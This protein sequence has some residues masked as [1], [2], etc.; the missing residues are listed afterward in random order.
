MDACDQE[1]LI[2][3]QMQNQKSLTL[4]WR[5]SS[6]WGREHVT[7]FLA[8]KGSQYLVYDYLQ[9]VAPQITQ[10]TLP[11][12]IDAPFTLIFKMAHG[13]FHFVFWL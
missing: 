10:D 2:L 1:P 7:M 13:V 3:P 6:E 4:H 12:I 5:S 11:T 9:P 8:Y